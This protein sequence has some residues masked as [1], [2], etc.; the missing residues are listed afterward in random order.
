MKKYFITLVA[1]FVA[2]TIAMPV[3]A[4]SELK[5][6]GQF[7]TRFIA[8]N[9]FFDGFD[10]HT[11]V[12]GVGVFDD[13]NTFVDTRLRL[14]F[15]YQASENLRVVTR[16]EVGDS[17]WGNVVDSKGARVG[18]DMTAVEIK[19]AYVDFAI[20][21]CPGLRSQIGIQG[22]VLLNSWIIDD[23]FAAAVAK[24]KFE[25]VTVTAGYIAAQNV[26]DTI[27]GDDLINLGQSAIGSS[28]HGE[29]DSIDDLFL[30]VTY[31]QGPWTAS[32]IFFWQAGHDT[33]ASIDPR[34]MTTPQ[35]A[36]TVPGPRFAI[37][38]GIVDP[39]DLSATLPSGLTRAGGQA[40]FTPIGTPLG[41]GVL[42][43][44]PNADLGEDPT[45]FNIQNNN[46]VDLGFNV[47]YK[48]DAWNAYLSFV[49]NLGGFDA[50][51]T[52]GIR[53]SYDY[54][55]WM[56]DAGFNYFCGPYTFNIGGFYITGQ[57]DNFSRI[58]DGTIGTDEFQAFTY[59]LATSKYFSEILGGGILDNMAPQ[60]VDFTGLPDSQWRGY[61]MPTNLWTITVGGA[62]QV[63]EKTKISA[64]YWYFG[65]AEDVNS[66]FNPVTLNTETDT[67]IGHEFNLYLTQGIVD[68]LTLD[69]VGAYLF[70]D[71]AY[72]AFNT[73]DDVYELGARIQWAF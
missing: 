66:G 57:E 18:A 65:T 10:E 60:H 25:P 12:N 71:D 4:A 8:Q 34:T 21:G 5:Y 9:N 44:A 38:D 64:S 69:L 23:D 30:D 72:S 32:A 27:L 33:A 28:F 55:G 41:G 11:N 73:D 2:M 48:A 1:L 19:N 13:K 17:V 68:G 59:P 14:F 54:T 26:R 37:V 58:D 42:P 7:R 63:L 20:P 46:L 16:F 29:H 52:L 49:K 43:A 53:R 3:F 47:G 40:T 31:A 51:D 70:T 56:V 39:G 36:I 61:G 15:I 22:L 67:S 35:S 62:W 50:N 24:Y 45:L 6:G